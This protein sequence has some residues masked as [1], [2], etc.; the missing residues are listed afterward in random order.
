MPLTTNILIA[1][2]IFSSKSIKPIIATTVCTRVKRSEIAS[3]GMPTQRA[4]I[5][6]VTNNGTEIIIA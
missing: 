2:E 1:I 4:V 5:N 6:T 3:T